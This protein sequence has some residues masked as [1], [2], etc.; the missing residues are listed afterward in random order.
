MNVVSKWY[1]LAEGESK[2]RLEEAQ[3]QKVNRLLYEYDPGTGF[4]RDVVRIYLI[5]DFID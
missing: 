3:K 2:T 1:G 4:S 5:G